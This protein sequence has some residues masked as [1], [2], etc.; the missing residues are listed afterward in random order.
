M[1]QMRRDV[2]KKGARIRL[3]LGIF[4]SLIGKFCTVPCACN[5]ASFFMTPSELSHFQ[6]NPHIAVRNILLRSIHSMLWLRKGVIHVTVTDAV[7][8]QILRKFASY[9]LQIKNMHEVASVSQPK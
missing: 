4:P 3:S 7:A 9:N 1:L 8:Q 6:R 5:V 2:W